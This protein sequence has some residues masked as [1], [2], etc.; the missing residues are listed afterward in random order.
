MRAFLRHAKAAALVIM[1]ARQER[2][3]R[4]QRASW[5]TA[6]LTVLVL[7]TGAVVGIACVAVLGGGHYALL[8]FE[9]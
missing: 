8:S 5:A 2:T 7:V 4:I 6:Q 9:R 1:T 3:A